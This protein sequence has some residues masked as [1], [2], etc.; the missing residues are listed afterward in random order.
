MRNKILS[1]I[2]PFFKS[3]LV[4]GLV[5][6]LAFSHADG[7][8]AARTGGRMGGSGGFRAP[9]RSYSPPGRTYAPGG[10][11]YY[12]APYPGGGGFGF[13]LLF[14]FFFGGGG[15]GLFSILI[16]LAIANFL[17][18]SFRRVRAGDGG[19]VDSL[20]YS[21]PKVSVARVQVGLLSEARSLQKELDQLARTADTSSAEGRAQVLQE[22]TLALLRHPEYW[23]YGAGES[24]QT[25]LQAAE[26][27]FNQ[28]ALGERSKFTEETLSN[29]NNQLRAAAPKASLPGT[30]AGG[31]L[32]TQDPGEYLVVTMVVGV[33]GNLEL[34]KINSTD[35]LRQAL[36][37][38]GGISSDRL[39]AVEVLWTPQADGDTLT[40]DDLLAEYPDLKLV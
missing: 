3:L 5:L 28:L 38:I 14:P 19:E 23:V 40:T 22:S 21:N 1:T 27:K 30:A 10:G 36:R 15:G 12:P 32:M 13:P 24:Q 37:Q 18:S 17:V 9:S 16:F 26:A 35:D 8:L 7:A 4:I 33:E 31:E 39:L 20:G 6:T 2:K 25:A 29:V 11:G 34:P